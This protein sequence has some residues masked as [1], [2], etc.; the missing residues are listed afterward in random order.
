[1]A[2]LAPLFSISPL[3][4]RH[5]LREAASSWGGPSSRASVA[6]VTAVRA[7]QGYLIAE[8]HTPQLTCDPDLTKR[9]YSI[10]LPGE[11]VNTTK[12]VNNIWVDYPDAA[13][14]ERRAL[15]ADPD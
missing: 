10:R 13:D 9:A 1:M 3:L 11:V 5:R 12:G 7:E 15:A 2:A 4:R 8:T 14:I 6:P